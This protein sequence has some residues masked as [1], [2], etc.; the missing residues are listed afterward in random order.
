MDN[1]KED[2][3]NIAYDRK[4]AVYIAY[5]LETKIFATG[6]CVESACEEYRKIFKN[7]NISYRRYGICM[8]SHMRN[9]VKFF[10]KKNY[11][12]FKKLFSRKPTFS[13]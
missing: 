12:I 1:E 7:K 5:S 6:V 10:S 4:N 11:L 13:R 8:E 3:I 9:I 2:I